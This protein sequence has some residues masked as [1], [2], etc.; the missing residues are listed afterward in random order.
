MNQHFAHELFECSLR[1]MPHFISVLIKY[2]NLSFLNYFEKNKI[3]QTNANFYK[4]PQSLLCL[5]AY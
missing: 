1:R 5:G 2:F 4:A 3:C